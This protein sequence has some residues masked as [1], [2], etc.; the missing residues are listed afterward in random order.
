[1]L[2]ALY[3]NTPILRYSHLFVE[4]Q[5]ALELERYRVSPRKAHRRDKS[6]SKLDSFIRTLEKERDYYKNECDV[7]N[8]V[9]QVVYSIFKYLMTPTFR[10]T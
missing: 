3:F 6:P 1:M 8:T 7:L 5:L 10:P 4:K 9:V 2:F